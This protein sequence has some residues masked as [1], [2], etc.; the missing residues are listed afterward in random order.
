MG[1]INAKEIASA[2]LQSSVFV[3]ARRF[4]GVQKILQERLAEI[5]LPKFSAHAAECYF[6]QAPVYH[7]NT[8]LCSNKLPRVLISMKVKL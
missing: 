4:R 1:C 7:Q 3:G 5:L 6:S 2:A 8:S